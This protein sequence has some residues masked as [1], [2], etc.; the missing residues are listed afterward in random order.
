MAD[1]ISPQA[2]STL[3]QKCRVL[4]IYREQQLYT[5]SMGATIHCGYFLAR[6]SANEGGSCKLKRS[7]IFLRSLVTIGKTDK[8]AV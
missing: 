4:V 1:L 2:R 3:I 5:L 6:T 8:T 7:T